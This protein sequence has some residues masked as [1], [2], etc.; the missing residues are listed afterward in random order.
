MRRFIYT[1][2]FFILACSANAQQ[3]PLFTQYMF[4][5]FVINP[6]VAGSD[7]FYQIRSGNRFQWAGIQ[8]PPL[9]NTL[10]LYGPFGKSMGWGAS[11]YSDFTGPLSKTGVYLSYAFKF[12]LADKTYLSLGVSGGGFQYRLDGEK[13][14]FEFLDDPLANESVDAVYAPDANV[15]LYLYAPEYKLGISAHQLINNKIRFYQESIP[16]SL[17]LVSRLT[18]HFYV[19][20]TYKY[21]INSLYSIEPGIHVKSVMASNVQVDISARLIY[22]K[23]LW[24]GLSYRT[25]NSIAGMVGFDYNKRIILGYAYD[26]GFG[27]L[28]NLSSIGSHELVIGIKFN[29]IIKL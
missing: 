5:E 20:G 1:I 3:V 29:P 7:D 18:S 17:N 26:F 8:D 21:D 13:M 11:L 24:F 9:T 27:E 12:K 10:S 19:F 16:D 15:G 28:G 22:R 6:A 14:D 2:A 25:G 23:Q 4:N